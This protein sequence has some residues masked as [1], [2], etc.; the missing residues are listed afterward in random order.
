MSNVKVLDNSKLQSTPI[1]I[2]S[3]KGEQKQIT[4]SES[5]GGSVYGTTP[6]GTRIKYD[7][8]D[9]LQFRFSPYSKT[10]PVNLP[11]I[12]GVTKKSIESESPILKVNKDKVFEE[13]K[14][15][16]VKD[17]EI[18]ETMFQMEIK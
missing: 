6:G 8:R 4:F 2:G 17:E 1:G 7:R 16:E 10:P 14:E 13:K 18:E 3:Q 5:V 9:L 12:E 15:E 11:I